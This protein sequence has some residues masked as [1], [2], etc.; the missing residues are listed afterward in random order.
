M[1]RRG[2]AELAGSI[3]D[4]CVTL[5]SH[6][7]DA[8]NEAGVNKGWVADTNMSVLTAATWRAGGRASA[9]TKCRYSRYLL[10]QL[11]LNRQ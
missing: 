11:P 6:T 2:D 3:Y 1:A 10:R 4:N 9:S 5:D 8:G 7:R